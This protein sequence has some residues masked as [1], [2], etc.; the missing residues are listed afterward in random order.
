[1]VSCLLV[2][3]FSFYW[4]TFSS[5]NDE[6]SDHSLKSQVATK[7]KQLM[8]ED[9]GWWQRETSR[10]AAR[11]FT[12]TLTTRRLKGRSCGVKQKLR[13]QAHGSDLLLLLTLTLLTKSP[14]CKLFPQDETTVCLLVRG[15]WCQRLPSTVAEVVGVQRRTWRPLLSPGLRPSPDHTTDHIT[16]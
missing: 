3:I 10:S 8:K 16:L 5:A 4:K 12:T 1:M 14:H 7:A 9:L 2:P 15:V 11:N 13:L 6:S